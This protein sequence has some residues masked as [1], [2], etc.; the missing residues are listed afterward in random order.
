MAK[1]KNNALTAMIIGIVGFVLS[2]IPI[3]DLTLGLIAL[4]MGIS[5]LKK[6]NKS[7]NAKDKGFA[8][9]AII[10]GA[11]VTLAGL[12]YTLGAIAMFGM[13]SF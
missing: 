3:I 1:E 8:I 5:S 6:I 4:F 7:K 9:T 2:W 11:L 13:F 10:L 12:F